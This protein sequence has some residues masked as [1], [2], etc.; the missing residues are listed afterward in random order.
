MIAADF[1]KSG[2]SD[3]L[4]GLENY[5]NICGVSAKSGGSQTTQCLREETQEE[6]GSAVAPQ[7]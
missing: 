5:L 2:K 7:H 1:F 6:F 4:H 3:P